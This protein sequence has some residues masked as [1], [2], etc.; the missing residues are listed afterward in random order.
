MAV[1]RRYRTVLAA[2]LSALLLHRNIPVWDRQF[3]R[4]CTVLVVDG[5][6]P[7]FTETLRASQGDEKCHFSISMDVSD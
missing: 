7:M 3:G 4:D 5:S 6:E 1:T 2:C